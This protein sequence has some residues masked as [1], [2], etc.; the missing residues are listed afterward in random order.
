MWLITLDAKLHLAPIENMEGGMQNVLDIG[1]GTGIWSIEFGETHPNKFDVESTKLTH[2]S[3]STYPSATVIGV[4][5]S[6]IQPHLYRTPHLIAI[7]HLLIVQ[8][9]S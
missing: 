9:S 1:T 2:A 7:V 6:P 8:R 5:L 3:A 4:D